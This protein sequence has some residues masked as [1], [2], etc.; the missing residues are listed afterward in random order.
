[1]Q[2]LMITRLKWFPSF[3]TATFIHKHFYGLITYTYHYVS[4]WA[5]LISWR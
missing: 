3:Q 5:T 1:M 2:H 4:L